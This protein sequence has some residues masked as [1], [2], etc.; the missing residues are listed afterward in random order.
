[1]YVKGKKGKGREGRINSY[2]VSASFFED[3]PGGVDRDHLKLP[4]KAVS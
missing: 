1:M 2:I 3:L 4:L